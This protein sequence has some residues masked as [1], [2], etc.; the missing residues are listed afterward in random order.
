[1]NAKDR[2]I[3]ALDV[4]TK[5][6][7]LALV[8]ELHD[9]V[10]VFKIGMQLY[11]GYGPDI[12]KAISDQGA[13]VFID[14]KFHDIPNTVAATSKIMTGLGV[15]MFNVHASGGSKMMQKAAEA[16]KAE[17]ERLGISMPL[18]LAVTI[19]TS[20]TRQDLEYELGM[21]GMEVS[22]MV[23][24]WALMAQNSGIQGIVC[25]P[26]EIRAVRQTCGPDFRIV[27]PGIRPSWASADDQQRITTPRAALLN[28]ADYIVI[29][30][31][32][33]KAANRC[34]AAEKIIAEM[35]DA[36]A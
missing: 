20:L 23:S 32:I 12:V 7:A 14:L 29:G 26:Q 31:P 2:I 6:E 3:L 33:T 21:L 1:M 28:G 36:H 25:S 5:K 11:N 19:L 24:K 10:G 8:R 34:E 17:A 15:A 22:H 16:A 27:T 13:R 18:L 35:E 9:Y 4:D 30:R